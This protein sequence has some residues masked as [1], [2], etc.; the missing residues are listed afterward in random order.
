MM[1]MLISIDL[2]HLY[3]F[4]TI[5]NEIVLSSDLWHKAKGVG[6]GRDVLIIFHDLSSHPEAVPRRSGILTAEGKQTLQCQGVSPDCQDDVAIEAARYGLDKRRKIVAVK[7]GK[8]ARE[9]I[10]EYIRYLLTTTKND[11]GRIMHGENFS[12]CN[13][14]AKYN[15]R[16]TVGC[17]PHV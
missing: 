16:A 10:M 7:S 6:G 13:R 12:A 17:L 8:V 11:G 2:T 3:F 5:G 4:Q 15:L 1:V 14:Q 9:E